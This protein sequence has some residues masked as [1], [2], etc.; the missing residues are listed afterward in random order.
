MSRT[1]RILFACTV[2]CIT[3][4]SAD[5]QLSVVTDATQY[6]QGDVVPI[7]IHNAGPNPAHFNSFPACFIY[8]LG[9]MECVYGCLG[10]PELWELNVGQ[11]IVFEYDPSEDAIPDAIGWYRVELNGNS[12][13][14]GNILHCDYR[15][16]EIVPVGSDTWGDVKALFR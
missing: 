14:P 1:T 8:H 3:A 13:D 10:L 7:T 6:S 2:L 9:T 4:A 15:V 12:I 5:A 16:L 11:T